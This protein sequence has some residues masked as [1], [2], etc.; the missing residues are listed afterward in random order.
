MPAGFSTVTDPWAEA[1]YPANMAGIVRITTRRGL[2]EERLAVPRGEPGNFLTLEEFRAKFDALTSPW[3]DEPRRDALAGDLLGLDAAAS[4]VPMLELTRPDGHPAPA[5]GRRGLRAVSYRSA[6]VAGSQGR[7][8]REDIGRCYEDFVVGDIY[9][10]RPGRT[11]SE[12][13]N[14]WFTLLT[15]NTHPQHFDAVHAG[16]TEFGKLLVKLLP[17]AVDRRGHERQ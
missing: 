17:D 6:P 13:D 12:A 9:E 7:R 3:L 8:Y 2:F 11:I 1:E 14:T 16:G 4:V 5:H 10:H 15:M